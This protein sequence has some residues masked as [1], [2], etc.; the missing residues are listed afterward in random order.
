MTSRGPLEKLPPRQQNDLGGGGEIYVF[1]NKGQYQEWG[2]ELKYRGY[3][4]HI[5]AIR[6]HWFYSES[7]RNHRGKETRNRPA[8]L[9]TIRSKGKHTLYFRK[10]NSCTG[11]IPKPHIFSHIHYTLN[12][13]TGLRGYHYSHFIKHGNVTKNPAGIQERMTQP[14]VHLPGA[15]M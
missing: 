8:I 3:G 2:K 15:C 5:T 1:L 14:Q 7:Q 9:C 13:L 12:S 10:L 4:S 11:V 6:C